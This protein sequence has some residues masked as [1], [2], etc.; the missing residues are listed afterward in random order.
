M[1]EILSLYLGPA[2]NN[3]CVFCVADGR[4]DLP[5]TQKDISNKLMHARKIGIDRLVLSGGECTIRKDILMVIRHAKELGYRSIQVQTNGRKFRDE[6]FTENMINSGVSEISISLHG[7]V[8]QIHDALTG[9]IGSFDETINGILNIQKI[10]ESGARIFINSVITTANYL[11]L[12]D[13]VKLCVALQVDNIQFAYI[14][15]QGRAKDRFR[16][17]SPRKTE[18]TKHIIKAIQ[19]ANEAGYGVG[20]VMVEAFPYCLLPD[21]EAY[22]SDIFIPTAYIRDLDK[23]IDRFPF[24][25]SRSKDEKCIDCNFNDY[26]LGPWREYPEEYGWAEFVPVHRTTPEIAFPTWIMKKNCN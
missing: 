20:R 25:T 23:G 11:Y 9:I 18:I 14:H 8:P 6:K 4:T 5:M 3:R 12:D 10:E 17:L 16:E 21:Y 26:C 24:E 2:C 1:N 7:H 15:A 13:M 19:V 22:S